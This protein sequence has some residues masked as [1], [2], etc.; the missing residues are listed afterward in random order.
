MISLTN[1]ESK[2][3]RKKNF[4]IYGIKN[5]VPMTMTSQLKITIKYEIIVITPANTEALL[6]IFVT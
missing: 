1:E 4:V 2:S 6:V 3:H 5:L